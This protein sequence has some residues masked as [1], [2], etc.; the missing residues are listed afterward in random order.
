MP[1]R[2]VVEV[3][4]E[5]PRPGEA[6][7]ILSMADRYGLKSADALALLE[8]LLLPAARNEAATNPD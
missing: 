1:P 5:D 4:E 7:N 3:E 6:R 2:L 8:A